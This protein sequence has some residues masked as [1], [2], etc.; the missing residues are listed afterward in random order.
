MVTTVAGSCTAMATW[1]VPP[2]ND[3][4]PGG[5]ITGNTH[6]PGDE[7]PIGT[8][9]VTYTAT[10]AQGNTVTCSFDVIVDECSGGGSSSTETVTLI[11]DSD[12]N[13]LE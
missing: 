8:T 4:C 2:F 5:G 3:N 9:T 1:D 6:N 13:F 7:F 12:L 11:S 10:D